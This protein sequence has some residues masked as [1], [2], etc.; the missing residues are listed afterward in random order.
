M[1]NP[2]LADGNKDDP[3]TKRCIYFAK[4]I[5]YGSLEIVNLFSYI[6]PYPSDLKALDKNIAIGNENYNYFVKALNSAEKIIAAW[7][8]NGTIHKRHKEIEEVID[9]YDID[10]FGT[11][12]SNGQPRHPLFL[13]NDIELTPYRRPKNKVRRL[14]NTGPTHDEKATKGEGTISKGGKRIH[15]D[16]WMWCAICHEEFTVTGIHLCK[17][18]YEERMEGYKEFLM[19]E[20]HLGESSTNDYVGRVNGVVKKGYLRKRRS[21]LLT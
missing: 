18:C 2:S 4:K 1:L 11:V 15:D 16:S 17:S 14:V 20:Y 8:E 3:T 7:G 13:P 12:K 5:G 10:C 21:S 9:G 19:Q 6:T